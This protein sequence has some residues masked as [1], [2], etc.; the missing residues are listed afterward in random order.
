MHNFYINGLK[1][2]TLIRALNALKETQR[3]M[4][5]LNNEEELAKEEGRRLRDKL[6]TACETLEGQIISLYKKQEIHDQLLKARQ[7][8]I[9]AQAEVIQEL[10]RAM[11]QIERMEEKKI[12]ERLKQEEHQS[13]GAQG[14]KLTKLS[15]EMLSILESFGDVTNDNRGKVPLKP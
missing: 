1:L 14:E 8:G 6:D 12:K 5:S 13:R 2:V 10:L 4:R 3:R 15:Q 7:E 9:D 11:V